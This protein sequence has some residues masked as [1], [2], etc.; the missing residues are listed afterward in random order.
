MSP[1]TQEK[2]SPAFESFLAES[3]NNDK[4]DAIVIYRSASNDL[5]P[6]RGRLKSLK[7]KLADIAARANAQSTA[8]QQVQAQLFETYERESLRRMPKS[9]PQHL[10]MTGIG[11]AAF[12]A[13]KM[14]VTRATL[15]ALAKQQDVVAILPNQRVSLI[16]PKE[17]NYQDLASS[18]AK[19]GYT[20]GLQELGVPELWAT[21]RGA[22][23]NV[24]VL[25]TGVYG[26]H[27]ALKGR[28][29]DFVM[30]D[31]LGRRIETNISFDAGRHGTHVCGTIAGGKTANGVSIGV[32]PEAQLLVGAVLVGDATLMTIFEGLSWAIEKGA[33]IVNMSLGFQYYEPQ[34][35]LIFDMLIEQYGI[36]PVAAIGNENH[37]STSSPG[38]VRNAFSVGALEKLSPKRFEIASF[39][40]GASLFFPGEAPVHKPD[41]VAPGVQVYSCIPPEKRSGGDFDYTYMDGTSMATPHIAGVVAL[42]MSAYPDIE[43]ERIIE[44]LKET[45]RHPQ[46]AAKR[47]DNRW[48]YGLIQPLEAMKALAS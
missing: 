8:H 17:I 1:S 21:T 41:I 6:L 16:G 43:P 32:A 33:D 9:K 11:S 3:G 38:N 30:V 27:P 26:E 36:L 47:P 19:S 42:L 25:D 10:A 2:I 29:K 31:P 46:G 39:S 20:W 24:A 18:E 5:P 22:Q 7:E 4:R 28:V 13:A 44:V 14:E 15:P 35:A 12:P 40:S 37:G 23:I 48:G 34:F 45:A